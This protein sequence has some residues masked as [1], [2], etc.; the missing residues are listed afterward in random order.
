MRII[1]STLLIVSLVFNSCL[2]MQKTRAG[3]LSGTYVYVDSSALEYGDKCFITFDSGRFSYSCHVVHSRTTVQGFFKELNS[4]NVLLVIDKYDILP[5]YPGKFYR[6]KDTAIVLNA[7]KIL[8]NKK[9][10]IKGTDSTKFLFH[11]RILK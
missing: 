11:G 3:N 7:Y 4:R 2:S 1:S 9:V 10:F 6:E 5:T 8:L